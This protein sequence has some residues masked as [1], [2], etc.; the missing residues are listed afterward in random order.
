MAALIAYDDLP[1]Q[2]KRLQRVLQW[3]IASAVLVT[4]AQTGSLITISPVP[5]LAWISLSVQVIQTG[6]FIGAWL[7][8]TRNYIRISVGLINIALLFSAIYTALV[9]PA[10]LPSLIL[11]PILVMALSMPYIQGRDIRYL[12][13]FVWFV[14]IG[15]VVLALYEVPFSIGPSPAS[16]DL[17]NLVLLLSFGLILAL[18]LFLL[19]QFHYRLMETIIQTRTANELLQEA[20][21]GLEQQVTTR[22]TELQSALRS[23]EQQASEQARLLQELEQQRTIIRNLSIPVLPVNESTLVI[24]LIGDLDVNRLDHGQARILEAIEQTRTRS[25]ILDVTGVPFID[26]Y[27]AQGLIRLIRAAQLL[28]A[29]VTVVGIRPEV[30][31]AIVGLGLPL[32]DLRTASDLHSALTMNNHTKTEE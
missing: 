21:K 10:S 12:S 9:V 6:C 20:Q 30:A 2:R 14:S 7:L 29:E 11:M 19:W 8:L 22:T 24:P 23:V 31:Q 1:N 16:Q 26:S 15:T 32:T 18:V 25:L 17:F 5:A 28:G 27:I 4:L 3:L 13:I